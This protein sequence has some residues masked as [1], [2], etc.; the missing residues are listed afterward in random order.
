[1]AKAVETLFNIQTPEQVRQSQQKKD[2]EQGKLLTERPGTAGLLFAPQRSRAIGQGVAGLF[3]A[4]TRSQAEID[5]EQNKELLTG[6]YQRAQQA[7]PTNRTAQLNMIAM[8]LAKAGKINEAQK[9]RAMAQQSAGVDATTAKT[10]AEALRAKAQEKKANA[11]A[12]TQIDLRSKYSAEAMRAAA[13]SA[14]ANAKALYAEA[15]ATTELDR[16]TKLLAD[17]K[18]AEADAN[19]LTALAQKAQAETTSEKSDLGKFLGFDI[20]DTSV[21]SRTIASNIFNKGKLPNESDSEFKERIMAGLAQKETT[22]EFVKILNKAYPNNPG[23]RSKALKNWVDAQATTGGGALQKEVNKAIVESNS[24]SVQ[25]YKDL[26]RGGLAEAD[27]ID[28]TADIAFEA[29]VGGGTALQTLQS[30]LQAVA[31]KVGLTVDLGSLTKTQQI[32]RIVNN[33]VLLQSGLIKGALSNAE[34]EFLRGSVADLGDTPEAL[35]IALK[36]L[37]NQKRMAVTMY[38]RFTGA[39]GAKKIGEGFIPFYDLESEIR[40]D[41]GLQDPAIFGARFITSEGT[42]DPQAVDITLQILQGPGTI[43]EKKRAIKDALGDFTKPAE[44]LLLEAVQQR[45]APR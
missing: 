28:A 19:R 30:G 40:S 3:G 6:I 25:S 9:A 32:E 38:N 42:V 29:I 31:D 2:L 24:D 7:Y 35:R 36:R 4:E 1:M 12:I 17:A 11:E 23:E 33:A 5:A 14:E 34:L 16:R 10:Q 45:R 15:Q 13:Q 27:R 41:L 26:A 43:T 22:P 20:K 18:Q 8:E 21:D 44:A 39:E 37:A